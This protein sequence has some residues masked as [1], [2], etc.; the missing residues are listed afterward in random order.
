MAGADVSNLS[1]ST[2]LKSQV[3]ATHI[4]TISY[5]WLNCIL[6]K[7]SITWVRKISSDCQKRSTMDCSRVLTKVALFTNTI[8]MGRKAALQWTT[9]LSDIRKMS[10]AR[11][12][13]QRSKRS[14]PEALA[15]SY[16][17]HARRFKSGQPYPVVETTLTNGKVHPAVD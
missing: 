3:S 13:A 1:C 4:F 2:N 12:A 7:R 11:D 8:C 6:C 9:S 10:L 17:P 5:G 14:R 15:V 16:V